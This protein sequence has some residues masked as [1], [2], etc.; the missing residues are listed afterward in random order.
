MNNSGKNNKYQQQPS[1]PVNNT[2][3]LLARI[4]RVGYN[5]VSGD[6]LLGYILTG[7]EQHKK[8]LEAEVQM[9]EVKYAMEPHP[10]KSSAPTDADFSGD[11]VYGKVDWTNA[12]A[13]ININQIAN[14]PM[15]VLGPSNGGKTSFT[16]VH[17]ENLRKHRDKIS[18]IIIESKKNY[19]NLAKYLDLWVLKLS[20][21][22]INLLEPAPGMPVIPHVIKLIEIMS[23]IY[24]FNL[25]EPYLFH[26]IQSL[27]SDYGVLKGGTIYPCIYDVI[28]AIQQNQYQFS[29]AKEDYRKTILSV[30][31]KLA[32]SME[33]VYRCSQSMPIKEILDNGVIIETQEI[34]VHSVRFILAYLVSFDQ[35]LRGG[36]G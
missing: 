30:L 32:Y 27:L 9:A 22:R 23:T 36:N 29:S 8:I 5:E 15:V 7:N 26:V 6:V 4:S 16:F 28:E 21:L 34:P 3:D 35:E 20:E 11:L 13:R 25:S 17:V 1:T 14:S 2:L 10:L 18:P 24:W 31:F 12:E 19:R 33:N